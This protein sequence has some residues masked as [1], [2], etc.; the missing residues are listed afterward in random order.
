MPLIPWNRGLH[1]PG[2]Y[3]AEVVLIDYD[4]TTEGPFGPWMQ[5][6][7]RTPEGRV[8][9]LLSGE[10]RPGS[11]LHTLALMLEKAPPLGEDLDTD[12]LVE[13]GGMVP[14][15][16]TWQREHGARCAVAALRPW[17]EAK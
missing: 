12:T 1:P 14:I 7:Y 13:T 6:V 9:S 17:K 11:D 4:P 15:T 10:T 2:D 5:I 8:S 16:V 3:D